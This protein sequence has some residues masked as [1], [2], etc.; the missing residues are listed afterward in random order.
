MMST[1]A[2]VPAQIF[3]IL[4]LSSD[5]KKRKQNADLASFEEAEYIGPQEPRCLPLETF[6]RPS[7]VRTERFVFLN[8]INTECW[9][10]EQNPASSIYHLL[11]LKP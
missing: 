10:P 11:K 2:I 3:C 8:A 4:Y 5:T 9:V 6:S 1:L 7:G